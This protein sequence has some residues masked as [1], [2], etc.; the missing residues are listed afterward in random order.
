[1]R[2]NR[3]R[4]LTSFYEAVA[5]ALGGLFLLTDIVGVIP[6]IFGWIFI[7]FA[8]FLLVESFFKKPVSSVVNMHIVLSFC[9]FITAAVEYI[10]KSLDS[11]QTLYIILSVVFI[12]L[13]FTSLIFHSFVNTESR[14]Y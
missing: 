2:A 4:G 8:A 14:T 9:L 6:N 12:V 7:A 13:L 10:T 3:N 5:F 11:G 1:M